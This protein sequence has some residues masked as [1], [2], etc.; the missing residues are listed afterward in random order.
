MNTIDKL[1]R[2]KQMVGCLL[3]ERYL[4]ARV[5]GRLPYS[6]RGLRYAIDWGKA[7][8]PASASAA[9]HGGVSS[10]SE[11]TALR[12][13]FDA[14]QSGRGILKWD[15]YFEIYDRHLSRFVGKPVVIIEVGVFAG[16]SLELWR[17]YFGEQCR[18]VGIDI[19]EECREYANGYTDILI[20]DQADRSFWADVRS[21]YPVVDIVIDDGGHQADQQIVTLEEILPHLRPGGVYLCEDIL[22]KFNEFSAYLLGLVDEMN[23]LERR[24][25]PEVYAT[26]LQSWIA[27]LSLYPYVAVIEKRADPLLELFHVRAG[28]EWQ[29]F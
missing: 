2:L 23:S 13:L 11:R 22:K 6:V 7:Q 1:R 29:K 10:E 18:V 27:S 25:G 19:Q 4:G 16:G 3:E 28:T 12:R 24:G 20:G 8:S 17:Q 26:A 5:L 21:R 14:R 15:H 9:R